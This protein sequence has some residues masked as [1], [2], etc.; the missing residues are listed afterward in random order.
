M[1]RR[2]AAGRLAVCPKP[3]SMRTA[4]SGVAGSTRTGSSTAS[5]PA[6]ARAGWPS[7]RPRR[8]ASAGARTIAGGSDSGVACSAGARR[9]TASTRYSGSGAIRSRPSPSG[10]PG[11]GAALA[12]PRDGQ[13]ASRV[14]PA[15]RP[16]RSSN[17]KPGDCSSSA[18]AR[19]RRQ[20]GC[21]LPG[22]RP[23]ATACWRRPSTLTT[24]ASISGS[25]P[26]GRIS[27]A[28]VRSASSACAQKAMVRAWRSAA[29]AR[30][31]SAKSSRSAL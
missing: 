10:P 14:M 25:R 20:P 19:S 23:P 7:A 6:D 28:T 16:A 21:A 24:V 8:V 4:P 11:A 1:R 31:G 27:S 17:P 5:V 12:S 9:T 3:A 13:A 30:A 26:I 29:P 15:R 18:S 22:R 2:P